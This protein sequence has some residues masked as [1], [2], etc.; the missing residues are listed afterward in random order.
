MFEGAG[1]LES[2]EENVSRGCKESPV[3]LE[4]PLVDTMI[5]SFWCQREARRAILL[6]LLGGAHLTIKDVVRLTILSM[7]KKP[8]AMGI[9]L[10]EEDGHKLRY[11]TSG[12]T[13]STTSGKSTQAT[14][15]CFFNKGD[16]SRVIILWRLLTYRVPCYVVS[17]GSKIFSLAILI[18]KGKKFV[19]PPLYLGSLYACWMSALPT[20]P[21]CQPHR[22][23]FPANVCVGAILCCGSEQMDYLELIIE[24]AVCQDGLRS[25]RPSKTYKP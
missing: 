19:L 12:M 9:V 13:A 22:L 20:W 15:A 24:E 2:N 18:T 25:L 10:E 4:A 5:Q 6:W 8:N 23:I 21:H 11:L 17:I 7:F 16:G 1:S 14:W 3:L